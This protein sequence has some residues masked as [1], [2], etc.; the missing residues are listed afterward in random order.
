[1]KS[2]RTWADVAFSAFLHVEGLRR[3][4]PAFSP[5]PGSSPAISLPGYLFPSREIIHRPWP[6]QAG[7]SLFSGN[8]LMSGF[9]T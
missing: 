1:M 7:D 2:S 5:M 9:A 4:G 6:L 8:H 3:T